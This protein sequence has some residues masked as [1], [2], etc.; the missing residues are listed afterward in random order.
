MPS[1]GRR[2]VRL[3]ADA[4]RTTRRRLICSRAVW[5]RCIDRKAVLAEQARAEFVSTTLLIRPRCSSRVSESSIAY[6]RINLQ[7][8]QR[9]HQPSHRNARV[10]DFRAPGLRCLYSAPAMATNCLSLLIERD[11]TQISLALLV[12]NCYTWPVSP[13]AATSRSRTGCIRGPGRG[14]GR[15]S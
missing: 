5:V 9:P 8:S 3:V 4:D 7:T 11:L 12:M 2:H 15:G 10:N 6:L 13:T 14:Q 1:P